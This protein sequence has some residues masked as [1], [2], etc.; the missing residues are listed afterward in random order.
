MECIIINIDTAFCKPAAV[1]LS[2]GDVEVC[3]YTFHGVQIHLT[4]TEDL[5]SIV[6]MAACGYFSAAVIA[7][8]IRFVSMAIIHT[9]THMYVH[10]YC[11][12]SSLHL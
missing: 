12:T 2:H 9:H 8:A 1:R 4:Q 10:V 7:R 5:S 3:K 11:C 6:G